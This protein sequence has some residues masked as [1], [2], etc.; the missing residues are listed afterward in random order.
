MGIDD[1]ALQLMLFKKVVN[2]RLS[3]REIEDIARSYSEAKLK[4]K[5][6]AT[7]SVSDALKP[8][9]DTLSAFFGSKVALKR[10]P[11]GNGQILVSFKN[12]DDLNR[13]LDLIEEKN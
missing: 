3:V 1:I 5:A 12:D 11:N 13:I 4:K 9:Q 10:Q 2:E 8:V 6:K 7:P